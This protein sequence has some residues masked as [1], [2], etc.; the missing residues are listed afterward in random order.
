MSIELH[1]FLLPQEVPA[2]PV[3]AENSSADGNVSIV[4]DFCHDKNIFCY[5]SLSLE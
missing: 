2:V 3:S 4:M 1:V 5:C